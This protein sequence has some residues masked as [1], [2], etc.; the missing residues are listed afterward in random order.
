M[1]VIVLFNYGLV[2]TFMQSTL[3]AVGGIHVASN[4]H[5]TVQ[6]GGSQ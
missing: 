4:A 6:G 5:F 3:N 1:N 2:T